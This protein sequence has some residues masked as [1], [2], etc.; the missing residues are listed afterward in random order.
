[1]PLV[2]PRLVDPHAIRVIRQHLAERRRPDPPA[3]RLGDP[4]LE[5]GADAELADGA[6]PA[7]PARA[8]LVTEASQ[9]LA[10]VAEQVPVA[11]NIETGRP[12]PVVVTVV[13]PFEIAVGTDPE[14][15]IHQIVAELAGAR[16]EP[17]GPYV[18]RRAHQ[19][20]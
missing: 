9:I 3:A 19:D 20:P 18:R 4:I 8:A 14:V 15:V 16:P 12:A 10:S 13:E 17:A 7:S 1:A 2:A 6:I 11:R 5:R